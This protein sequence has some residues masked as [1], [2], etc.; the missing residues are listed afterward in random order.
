M[1]NTVSPVAKHVIDKCGGPKK[2]SEMLG[3]SL[4]QVYR[5]MHPKEKGGTGGLVPAAH[6]QKLL[7]EASAEGISLEP[8]DFFDL[9]D[10]QKVAS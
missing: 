5:M 10:E 9:P 8:A 7:D 3:I 2:V 6:Q 1:N 4:T